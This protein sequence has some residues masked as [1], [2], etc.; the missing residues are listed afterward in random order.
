M[1]QEP[2]PFSGFTYTAVGDG[3][4]RVENPKNGKH[5][6]FQWSGTWLEGEITH[7]D[8]SFLRFIGGPDLAPEDDVI[9]SRLRIIEDEITPPDGYMFGR[10]PEGIE[11]VVGKYD[12]APP[13][14]TGEGVRAGAHIE[15]EYFLDNDRK[16]EAIPDVYRKQSPMPG[17]AQ[18]V[19]TE[20]YFD[21]KYQ[22]MEVDRIWR[23]VWQVVCREDDI[24]E[25][26]DYHVYT[27]ADLSWLIV[28]VSETEIRAHQ[29]V[30]LHRGRILRECD[31]KK[32]TEFRCPYHGWSWK[33]DGSV[34]EIVCEWDFPDVRD[35]VSQLPG[36]KV[37]TW[38][39][40]VFINPDPE[41]MPLEDYL[42]PEMIAQY[43]KFD[44]ASFWK[45]A[46]V[47]RVVP[48]NWKAAMEAFM[49][50][51]H[52]V[53]THPQ[54]LL[55][56]WEDA[57]DRYDVFGHWGRAGH[58]TIGR[59]S[60]HRNII[61]DREQ[62]LEEY[63]MGAD[64]SREYHRQIIGDEVDMFSDA[65]L[66]DGSYCDLFPNF[67]PWSG[68]SRINFRFRPHG[69]DPNKAI[70]DV[71][72]IAPWPKDKPKPPPA[73]QEML[74]ENQ[75]WAEARSIG[76]LGRIIDQDC[77]NMVSVQAGLKAKYPRYTWYSSYQ[78]GKIRNFHR[79]YDRWMGS[80]SD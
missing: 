29:N 22:E 74:R 65:E 31:G 43:E 44:L 38:G 26:G 75:P 60:A 46:H 6:V 68:F 25:V 1:R 51:W 13:V 41:A 52:V 19:P 40:W 42:G 8:P 71:I 12:P 47:T 36:A 54:L 55:L 61:Y 66:N 50:G 23:R 21:P 11:R 53:A 72:L 33:L 79:N 30:C 2:H 48:A 63:R 5:G 70:M 9:W 67:H 78:E 76:T 39:G 24:P 80:N 58:V 16:P 73:K 27:V 49:E 10:I 64:S 7:A 35:D 62:L 69:S 57:A 20:R 77:D 34:K 56:G 4:V 3:T 28:R 15:L 45:Q 14:M 59:S 17:G 18:K 32:A 37:G